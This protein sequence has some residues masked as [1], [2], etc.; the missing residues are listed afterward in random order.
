MR[1]RGSNRRGP[2][3]LERGGANRRI[4]GAILA[5]AL[6]FYLI[7][8]ASFGLFTTGRPLGQRPIETLGAFAALLLACFGSGFMIGGRRGGANMV[9]LAGLIGV[10]AFAFI[11]VTGRSS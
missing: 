5:A 9:F 10:L 3:A 7:W 4:G 2:Q 11:V 6:L 1:S 8:A